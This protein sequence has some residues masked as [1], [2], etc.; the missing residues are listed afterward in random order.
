[1]TSRVICTL[2]CTIVTY[3]ALAQSTADRDTSAVATNIPGV[4]AYGAPP[5]SFDPFAA[6]NDELIRYGF[7]PRPTEA[8]ALERWRSSVTSQKRII[9][10]LRQTNNLHGPVR[11]LSEA[12][13]TPNVILTTSPN[14]SGFAIV[15]TAGTFIGWGSQITAEYNVPIPECRLMPSGS[16]HASQWV[17]FDGYGSPDV[18]QTGSSIDVNCPDNGVPGSTTTYHAWFEWYPAY[19]I[20]INNLPV[21]AG[22]L[23]SVSV[24]L[25][26]GTRRMISIENLNT[27]QTVVVEVSPP[28]GT[29]LVGNSVEWI[30]E[31]YTIGNQLTNLPDYLGI[32]MRNSIFLRYP[33]GSGGAFLK[34]TP[35][36]APTGS[37]YSIQMTDNAGTPVSQAE[38]NSL[39]RNQ[40]SDISFISSPP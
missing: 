3:S 33:S 23:M 12:K 20:A 9:P 21:R 13:V 10:E 1:V 18:L 29:S 38:V 5:S 26:D 8:R 31:R 34:Y 30:V 16:F 17:G 25:S 32:T 11:I 19:E 40:S 4:L 24:F 27:N 28:S 22:D 36:Q 2:I 37:I 35:G 14:W 7:P 6:T 39:D 15:D